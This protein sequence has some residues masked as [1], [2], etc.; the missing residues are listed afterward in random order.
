M[1]NKENT[2]IQKER[3]IATGI[4]LQRMLVEETKRVENSGKKNVYVSPANMNL[5][6]RLM[7]IV[8]ELILSCTELD[9]EGIQEKDRTWMI[10]L[11]LATAAASTSNKDDEDRMAEVFHADLQTAK[12]EYAKLIKTEEKALA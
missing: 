2:Q 11:A 6:K 3:L 10:G 8:S 7:H 4:T 9:M 5:I 1:D 12:A